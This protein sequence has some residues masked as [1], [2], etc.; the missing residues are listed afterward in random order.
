L[1]YSGSVGFSKDQSLLRNDDSWAATDTAGMMM[2]MTENSVVL[3]MSDDR[4][5]AQFGRS[6]PNA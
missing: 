5:Q 1:G 6:V 4:T 2:A 3:S